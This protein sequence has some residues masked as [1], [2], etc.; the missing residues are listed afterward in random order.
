VN[1][2]PN[3]EVETVTKMYHSTWQEIFGRWLAISGVLMWLAGMLL[4]LRYSGKGTFT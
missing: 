2:D 3:G 4:L 1:R